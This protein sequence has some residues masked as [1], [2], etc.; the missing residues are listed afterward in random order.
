MYRPNHY[1][2]GRLSIIKQGLKFIITVK[3]K[4]HIY[5]EDVKIFNFLSLCPSG[6]WDSL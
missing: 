1:L 4:M 3:M 6:T 5:T 2:R